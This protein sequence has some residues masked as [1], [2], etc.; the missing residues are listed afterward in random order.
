MLFLICGLLMGGTALADANSEAVLAKLRAKVR[1]FTSYRM[2][3][4]AAVESEGSAKGTLTVSGQRFA[5]KVL[6][7]ELYYDGMTLWSYTP[8]QQEVTVERLDPT[9]PSVLSNPSKLMNIN[10]QD[11]NH[12]S[13]PEVTVGGRKLRVVELTPKA[14]TPDYAAVTLYIDPGTSLPV[15]ISIYTPSSEKP[16]ELLV[17]GV[18][19]GI[20]VSEGTFRF[21]PKAHKGVEVID[22]R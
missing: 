14:K 19:S 15:R 7:Q 16:V 10:P 18:H 11:Y 8:K 1:S 6:G 12:R 20:P 21:D 13:L 3:F 2:D 5:A 4:T 22:F 17:D 9:N